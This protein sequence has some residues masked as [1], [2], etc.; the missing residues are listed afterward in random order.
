M[1][2]DDHR[3]ESG[4]I[5]NIPLAER[6]NFSIHRLLYRIKASQNCV[7]S[8]SPPDATGW[9]AGLAS[10]FAASSISPSPHI[11]I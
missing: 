5:A 2:T 11:F 7:P 8:P 9:K 4:V 3:L 1:M 6:L 10:Q